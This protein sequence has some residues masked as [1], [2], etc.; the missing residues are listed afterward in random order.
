MENNR[1]H[2][3]T[4][5]LLL[6]G[7]M[8]VALFLF[9]FTT[10]AQYFGRNKVKYELFDF[11]KLRTEHFEIYYYPS[12]EAAVD[13]AALM[14][15][16]WRH[17]LSSVF[18]HRL[19]PDQPVIIYANHADFQQT[20]VTAAIIG[21]G[22]GGFTEGM[23]N[24]IVLPLTGVYAQD[25]HVLGHELVH[26]FQYE[27]A[28]SSRQPGVSAGT[29]L[30]FIEGLAEYLSLGR[31]DPLTAMWLRDAVIND[32]IPSIREV[33][34][35]TR[36]FPY[37]YGHAIWIYL[38]GRWGDGIVPDLFKAVV[39]KGW[40]EACRQVLG[41][42]ADTVSAAWRRHVANT[43]DSAA[44]TLTPPDQVGRPVVTGHFDM[45][46]APV[47]SPDGRHIALLSR[48]DIFTIDL[49]LADAGTGE[50]LDKL[51]SSNS[52]A[53]FDAL[54][55]TESAGTWSPDGKRFA[56]V[57]VENG[58]NQ[59]FIVD[60]DEREVV[61]EIAPTG[62]DAM[63]SVAWSP[64]GE[65]IAISGI[66][67]G[68]SDIYLL[69]LPTE[70]VTR[71]TDGPNA[72]LQPA[73]SPDGS[74]LAFVTDM[75]DETNFEV[76][77]FGPIKI[78]LMDLES[79][80]IRLLSVPGASKSINPQ[81]S[82]DGESL[83]LI[84][85]PDGISNIY[86]YSFASNR[87][88]R[89][90]R[91]ATGISGLGRLSPAMSASR[92]SGDLVFSVFEQGG[93]N[94]YGMKPDP[95]DSVAAG[96][97]SKAGVPGTRP[98]GRVTDY[99]TEPREGLPV[100]RDF[101]ISDY[102]PSLRLLAVAPISAGVAVD[103]SGLSLG[104]G[105]AF[106]FGDMLGD[107]LLGV[108]VTAN[109]TFRDIGGEAVYQNRKRRY[110]WGASI[111]HVPSTTARVRS[112]VDTVSVNGRP[113]EARFIELIRERSYLDRVVGF[114]EYPLSMNRR[115]EFATGYTRLSFDREM[116]KVV[117]LQGVVVE[118]ERRDLA[119]GE[120]LNF[121]QSSLAYVGDYSFF[122]IGSP[123]RGKR[124]RFEV[125]PTLGSLTYLTANADYRHYLFLRPV[126]FAIR[127]LFRG[128]YLDD[129]ADSRLSPF[130]LGMENLVRGYSLGSFSLAECGESD[131]PERCPEVDRLLGSR[132]CVLGAEIRIPLLGP[133]GYAL[134]SFGY[135]PT[136]IAGFF[137]AGVAWT[138]D[139]TPV[140]EF[141]T[142]SQQ[143]I[144]V[145]STGAA[146]RFRV[147]GNLILQ[148]YYA[149][150]FQRPVKGGHFRFVVGSG[151]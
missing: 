14:L 143:R 21:Q 45:N 110:N 20:N 65:Q 15:E 19:S 68:V 107:H 84:A 94:I 61:R 24:R 47:I 97:L 53:H 52:D 38:T 81:F 116:E 102:K 57:A 147:L 43:Y 69:S 56:F 4:I 76:M 114:A 44:D 80:E 23:K 133:E 50:L 95:G 30:W 72:A 88:Y 98:A 86:R 129:A 11:H 27:M 49:Y 33:S 10:E 144:P 12:E 101:T 148:M 128:R 103:R 137:D 31:R 108:S 25:D 5:A 131:D 67:G 39:A 109:G 78:A 7:L 28:E 136:E 13:N 74:T 2:N 138:D 145:F 124:F 54:R 106:L 82:P 48:H 46:M 40:P 117:T 73:W 18:N 121:L 140:F 79:K 17:R 91:V 100:D 112:G 104:G 150:P 70:E 149:Y 93:Y 1:G 42:H 3:L 60:V 66:H 120:A 37:R 62:I 59:I 122:G 130:F 96:T 16:R 9:P 29:P 87:F 126:T 35:D 51:A 58:D 26:A 113:E 151:W 142:E 92:L 115:I 132:I 127:G 141:K 118:E 99:L 135:L 63:Q 146:L 111:G 8:T 6:Y 32:E 34:T 55:F 90:T 125:E 41:T 77:A 134:A 71:V 36:Y 83:Y 119:A 22:T 89:I 85:D 139:E 64:D 123:A 105:T 75:G